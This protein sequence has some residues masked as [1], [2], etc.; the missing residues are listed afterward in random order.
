MTIEL[1]QFKLN[2]IQSDIQSV[3]FIGILDVVDEL[4]DID[5][6]FTESTKPNQLE[7]FI[8][9]REKLRSEVKSR[10]ELQTITVLLK[11]NYY[12]FFEERVVQKLIANHFFY[13]ITLFIH[14]N[15][16]ANSTP[17][18]RNHVDVVFVNTKGYGTTQRRKLYEHFGSV[19]PNMKIFRQIMDSFELSRRIVVILC[20]NNSNEISDHIFWY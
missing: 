5:H 7:E 9:E 18:I 11:S 14:T 13:N 15:E 10:K 20:S 4:A 8:K 16:L 12:K 6:V 17:Q 1:R 2:D 19:V 3:L